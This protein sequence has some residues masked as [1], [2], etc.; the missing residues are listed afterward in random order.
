MTE[1]QRKLSDG[2]FRRQK[3]P[4]RLVEV[5]KPRMRTAVGTSSKF[6]IGV[7]VH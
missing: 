1:Y 6:R 3:V 4:E 5:T 2:H 7:G